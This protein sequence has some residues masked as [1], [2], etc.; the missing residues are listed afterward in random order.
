[1]CVCVYFN[2]C[3]K[4]NE[5]EDWNVNTYQLPREQGSTAKVLHS[6]IKATFLLN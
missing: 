2:I 3:D 1:M 4:N 6:G 5:K